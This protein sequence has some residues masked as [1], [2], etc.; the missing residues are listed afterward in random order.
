MSQ[1]EKSLYH[2]NSYSNSNNIYIKLKT[3]RT[4]SNYAY[5]TIDKQRK[6]RQI[7]KQS[8]PFAF[9]NAKKIASI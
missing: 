1:I 3:L 2:N 9:I 8:N 4:R 7:N 5:L 6:N